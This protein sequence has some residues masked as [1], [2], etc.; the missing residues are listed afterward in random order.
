MHAE[1]GEA[2]VATLQEQIDA[3]MAFLDELA[4]KHKGTK[5]ILLGHS[6]GSYILLNVSRMSYL[7]ERANHSLQLLKSR[8]N[9]IDSAHLLFPTCSNIGKSRQGK[10]LSPLFN[11]GISLAVGI[12]IV[13]AACTSFAFRTWIVSA[14]S[15]HRSIAAE[16]TTRFISSPAAV[17]SCLTLAKE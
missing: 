4:E 13:V 8:S 9:L 17:R 6:I 10:L 12:C 7:H 16:T 14:S 3:K 11:Y 2:R 5:I 15:G 1:Q